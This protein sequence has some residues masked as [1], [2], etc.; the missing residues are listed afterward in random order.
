MGDNGSVLTAHSDP[1]E[2]QKVVLHFH[3]HNCT[4][5][6]YQAK[7]FLEKGY[8]KMKAEPGLQYLYFPTS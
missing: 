3:Q 8:G 2:L 5:L 6:L 7:N 4:G 1:W